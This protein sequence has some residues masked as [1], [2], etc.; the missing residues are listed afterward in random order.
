M[1][2]IRSGLEGVMVAIGVTTALALPLDKAITEQID[3]M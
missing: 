2:E 3:E 1:I